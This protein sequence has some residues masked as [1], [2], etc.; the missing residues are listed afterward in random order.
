MWLT[1]GLFHE[2]V[3]ADV[4]VL[5]GVRVVMAGGDAL[6]SRHCRRV[7]DEV[8]GVRLVNV[9][10]PTEV[11]I[12]ATSHVVEGPVFLGGAALDT[13]VWVLDERLCPVGVGVEGELYV[14]GIGLAHGYGGRAGMTA[15]RFVALPGGSGERMYRTGDL[16]RWTA[17][18]VLDFVGRVDDQVKVRGFRVELGEVEEVLAGFPGVSR[19]VVVVRGDAGGVKRL[20]AYAVVEAGAGAES[21]A[22]VGVDG[23]VLRGFLARVLPDYMVPSVCVVVDG[24]PL[25]ANGKVDRRALPEPDPVLLCGGE[26]VAPRGVREGVVVGVFAEVLGLERVGVRDDFFGLGGDSIR[27][28]QVVSRLRRAGVVVPVRVL[29]DCRT[30]EGV[31]AAADDQVGDQVSGGVGLVPVGRGGV[32]PLSFAQARVWFAAEIDPEGTEYN[33]GGA[34]RIRGPLDVTALES[35]LGALVVRH[36]SLRTT[37][38]TVDGQGVQVIHP[39]NPVTLPVREATDEEAAAAVRAELETPFDLST[40]PLLRPLLLRTAEDEHLLVLSMHHIVT[41]GWSV[42]VLTRELAALYAG[43]PLPELPVQYADYAVWQRRTLT[44]PVL[45]EGL[46]YWREQLAGA[47]VLDLPTDRPRPAVR[48]RAGSTY[49][50]ELPADLVDRFAEV[51]R[52]RGVTLFMGLTAAVQLMLA[53]TTGQRD[54]VLGTATIGRDRPELEDV[55]GFFVNTLALRTRIDEAA[56][57]T[58]LLA[59]VRETVLDAFAHA[60]MPFDRVVDAVVSERDPART[61]LVQAMMVLQTSPWKSDGVRGPSFAAADLPRQDAQF[62]LTFEFWEHADGMRF[63]LNHNT[64]LFDATTVHS[65]AEHLTEVLGVLA[66]TPEL[67]LSRIPRLP[68]SE[69]T[70]VLDDWAQGPDGPDGAVLTDVFAEQVARAPEAVALVCG[71]ERTTYGELDARTSRLAH[72]LRTHGVGP[73][74]RVGV[75]LPRGTEPIVALLAVLKAGGVFVP[76]DTSY[77]AERLSYMVQDSGVEL[78]LADAS[79]AATVPGVGTPVLLLAE[80]EDLAAVCSK[81][82]Q[83]PPQVALAPQN[84]AYVFYTSGSTGRPK[85]IVLPHAGVLRVAR[86]PRL[87]TTAA[88]VVGQFATLSFDAS[89]LEIWSAFANGAA[90]V[91]STA[92]V[93]SV[94]ELGTLL[95]GRGVTVAWLT[96]GLFHEVVDTDVTML[97]GLRLLMAGGDALAPQHCRTV[98]ERLPQVRLVNGYGP[99]ETTVF[100]AVHPVEAGSVGASV[101]IGSPLGRTGAYVL[102]NWLRPVPAGAAGELYIAGEGVARGY[103]GHPGLTAGRFLP[104][105]FGGPG[106][107]MYRTGDVVRW[108]PDGQLEFV[109]RADHQV[110]VRGFRIEIGEIESALAAHPDVTQA[111][112]TVREGR[113]GAKRLVGYVVGDRVDHAGMREFVAKSLPDYMIPTAFVVVGTFPLT[114]NGKVDRRALPE[115]DL[116]TA[117]AKD[118]VA[119][120][121]RTERIVARAWGDVLGVERVGVQDNFFELG[122]DSILSIQ[123]VSRLRRAGLVVSPQDVLVRQ[124]VAGVAAV[125][126]E[127]GAVDAGPAVTGPV[128]LSPIQEWFLETRTVAPDHFGMSMHVRLAG[129]VDREVLAR[130]VPV[131]LSHHEG[132]WV[133][134][135]RTA[136]GWRQRVGGPVRVVVERGVGGVV[137]EGFRLE[138]GPLVRVVLSGDRLLIAVHHMVVDGVSWRILLEDIAVAYRQLA[139]GEDVVLDG[140]SLS[141]PE[142]TARLAAHDF[143]GQAEYWTEVLASTEPLFDDVPAGTNTVADTA[144]ETMTLSR[145]ETEALLQRVPSV[146]RTQVNDVLLAA[147]GRALGEWSGRDRILVDVEGHGREEAVIGADVSR[148]VGWFTSIYPVALGSSGDWREQIRSTKEMLRAVPDRGIGFGALR[149]LHGADLADPAQISFNYLGRYDAM[150]DP[151]VFAGMLPVDGDHAPADERPH[152]WDVVSRVQDGQLRIDLHHPAAA[153]DAARAREFAAR[154]RDALREAVA[155][156]LTDGT[157]GRTPSDFPLVAWDQATVDRVVGTG[158]GIADVHPLSPMQQGLLFHSL[159][160]DSGTAYVEQ[161]SFVLEGADDPQRLAAAWQEAVNASDAL[162]VSV[163][164]DQADEPAALV[165]ERVEIPVHTEDWTALDAAARAERLADLRRGDFHTIRLGHAPLMRLSLATLGGTRVQLVWTFHHLLLDGWSTP[166]LLDDVFTRY[167][168]GTP[169]VRAPYRDYLAW[170]DARDTD[171]DR[172]HWRT[173][174]AGYDTALTLPADPDAGP[175]DG[176]RHLDVAL[177]GTLPTEIGEFARRHRLTV[178]A[179]IQGA[180]A[181]LLSACSG[182]NDIVFGATTSGRPA[183]LA[184]AEGMLGLFIN[185]V[186]VRTVLDPAT[187]VVQ[188]LQQLQAEQWES[189]AHEYLSLPELT[190][191]ADLPAGTRLFES[192]LVF[193]NYPV[194][195]DLAARHGLAVTEADAAVQGGDYPLSLTAFTGRQLVGDNAPGVSLRVSYDPAVFGDR[196][197]RR[198][199]ERLATLLRGLLD[200]ESLARIPLLTPAER[201]RFTAGT[202][203]ASGPAGRP[204]PTVTLPGLFEAQAAR[205]PEAPAVVDGGTVLSY[206]ELDARA[207]GLAHRL[208]GSGI[209][210]ETVVGVSL[211]RGVD[212]LVSLLAV[213]KTGAVYLPLDPAHPADRLAFMA[214]DAGAR[215]VLG[216]SAAPE[217]NAVDLLAL[218]PETSPVPPVRPGHP[219]AAAYL[220]YTS[221]S[222]G[223]PKGVAVTHRGLRDLGAAHARALDLDGDSRILQSVSLGFDV[224]MGDLVNAWTVG[225]ALVLAG[226]D[227]TVGE[228]LARLLEEQRITHAML[229]LA[230]L[231]TLPDIP[232][233]HLRAL[234]SGGEAMPAEIPARWAPGRILVNAYG[235]TETTVAATLSDPLAPATATPPIG[236]AID[237]ARA[238]VLDG[239]LRPV[240]DGT[241]GELHLAGPGVARGYAGRPGL[242]ASAFVANPFTGGRMYRTGDLVRRR[243]DGQLEF[244][245]RTDHQVKVRGHRIEPGEVEAALTRHPAVSQAVAVVREDQPGT[246]RLVGYAVADGAHPAELREFVAR[247]LPE[248]MV[249]AVCVVLDA[250]PLNA[251]GKVDRKALPAPDLSTLVREYIAPATEAERA[252]ATVFAEVLGAERIGAADDFFGLGGDSLLSIQAVSRLR[253]A[254]YPAAVRTL[255]DH[256]TVAALAAEIGAADDLPGAFGPDAPPAPAARD[257]GALP[258][259]YAQRRLWF[260]AELDPESTEYNSGGALRL[261]GPLDLAAL[262]GALDALV[263]RHEPLRTT[264]A[265]ADGEAVQLIGPAAP[266][267]LP[268]VRCAPADVPGRIRAGLGVVFD[269][270]TGPLLRPTL[271]KVADE[272]HILVLAMHHM[273]TDGWS[274]GVVVRELDL[275]YRGVELPPLALQYADYAAW[276]RE[277]LTPEALAAGLDHWRARLA[278]APVLELPTDRPR[279]AERTWAG[280]LAEFEVPAEVVAR[281]TEVCRAR[282]VTL[283]MGLVAAVQLVLARYSGQQDVVVGT[284]TSGRDRAEL[285]DLIGFFVNTVALRT[286]IDEQRSVADLLAAVR[287]TVLDA[288]A[289]EEIPFDRVVDAVV[290]ER[291]PSRTPLVQALVSMETTPRPTTGAGLTWQDQ[292]FDVD[293]AQFELAVDFAERDGSLTAVINYNTGLF[294][295]ATVRGLGAHLATVVGEIAGPDKPLADVRMLTPEEEHT[296]THGWNDTAQ[297]IPE[298]LL[299]ELFAAQAARTPDAV[300]LVHGEERLTFAELDRAAG[301]LAHRLRERG[302]GPDTVVGICA[303][304]GTDVVVAL[305]GILRAGA[306]CLPIDPGYPADRVRHMLAD[307]GAATVLVQDHLADRFADYEGILLTPDRGSEGDPQAPAVPRLTADHL[308]YV[309]YTSGS[310]G[311]PKGTLIRHGAFR[312]LFAHHRRRMFEPTSRGR[313]MRM[314]QTASISFDASCVALLWLVGGH[315]LHPVDHETHID[316]R[317]FRDYLRDARIDVIDEAPTYL[318]ELIADGLLADETHVPSVIVFGGEAVDGQI[319]DTLRAHPEVTAYNFYGPTECTCDSLTW[320]ARGS[321]RPLIGRPVGNARA[322]VL[323]AR[324]RPVPAG[325]VG[326]LYIEG[327]GL[328]RGYVGKPGLTAGR[329]VACPFTGGRMYRSGDLVRWTREGTVEFL[330]R[331]DDQVKVRGF[332]IELGEIETVLARHPAVTQAVVVARE[333]QPGVKRLVAYVVGT[334]GADGADAAELR[335]YAADA[336]PDYMVP[337]AWLLLDAFP[338]NQSGK[339]DR[340]AL[341]APDPAA[342]ANAYTAPRTA[343]EK[344]VAAVWADVLGLERIGAHDNFFD[345]GGDSILSTRAVSRLRAAGYDTSVRDLFNAPTVAGLAPLATPTREPA[346][347]VRPVARDGALPLSYAQRRLWF[348]AELDPESTEYN[349]GIALRL[350][351][352]LDLVALRGALDALVAR[353]ESL[354]TTFTTAE[355]Q[356]VQIVHPAAPVPLPVVEPG[357]EG[358]DALVRSLF[359]EVFDLRGGPLLRPTLVRIGDRDHILVLSMHHI[360][361]DGWSM[362]VITRE[363]TGLYEGRT[364]AEPPVQYADYAVWQRERLTPQAMEHALDYWREQLAGAPVLELP[365]DRPRPA[366]RTTRGASFRT[367]IPAGLLARFTE[368][369]QARGATLFMGLTAA[370]KLLLS[371]Y[372]GQQDVV[373]GT[374][375][376]G[377]DRAELEGLVGF[378]VNTLAL[379]TTIDENATGTALLSSVRRTV[380]DAFA[381][382]EVPFDRVVDAVVTERDPSRSPLVQAVISYESPAEGHGAA[383]A[384]PAALSWSDHPLESRTS[385][386]DLTFDFGESDGEFQAHLVHNTDLFDEATI[387]RMAGHLVTI[388]TAL[389]DDPA[390]PLSDLELLSENE[391]LTLLHE[392]NATGSDI[393]PLSL[394]ALFERQRSLRPAA[395]AVVT[396]TGTWTYAQIDDRATALARRLRAEGVTPETVVG[397]CLPRGADWI[398]ALLAVVKAGGVY[399]PLDPEYPADRRAFMLTDSGAP[400]VLTDGDR[401]G[402]LDATAARTLLVDDGEGHEAVLQGRDGPGPVSPDAGAYLIYTSGSTGVPKG[403]LVGHRG[404]AAFAAT[405]ADRFTITPE[406]RVLQV[407]SANFDASVMEILMAWSV[408]A[409]LVLPAPGRVLGEELVEVLTRQRVTHAMVPPAALAGAGTAELPELRT[410]VVG[411]EACPPELV[412][413]WAPGRAMYNAY[414]PTEITISATIS[415]RLAPGTVPPIGRP[416][417]DT[418]VYVLDTWLRPVPAGVPGELYVTGAGVARGYLGRP[419][420]TAS[421]FVASPFSAERMY[422]TGDVVRWLPGGQLEFVGRADD[423]VKIRGFRIEPG[424]IESV[425]AA[426]PDVRQAVV[427]VREDQPGV[428]RLVAYVTGDAPGAAPD[429]ETLREHTA[430]SLPEYMVPAAWVALDTIPLTANGKLDRRA[431]PAPGLPARGDTYTAPRTDAERTLAGVWQALLGVPEVGVHDNF[432]DLGGDSILSIQVVARARDAGLAVSTKQLFAA[433]TVAALAELAVQAGP[434]SGAEGPG[435]TGPV[436]GDV[437]LTPIQR[438]FLDGERGSYDRFTMSAYA[439]LAERPDRDA[440]R[441]A[442]GALYEHHD[443]LRSRFTRTGGGWQ[444]SVVEREDGNWFTW[445]DLFQEEP[446]ARA[447]EMERQLAR[448]HAGLDITHGPLLKALVFDQGVDLPVRIALVA[449]HLVV[450]VVSWGVLLA[451]LARAYERIAAGERPG[452]GARTTSFQEWSGRLA[453]LA[454]AGRFDGEIAYWQEAERVPRLPGSGSAANTA[455]SEDTVSVRLDGRTTAALLQSAPGA[456]RARVNE[457]LL[458][459]LGRALADWTG[460]DRVAVALEGHG[461]EEAVVEGADLSRT[462]GWFTTVFPFAWN[463]SGGEGW[464]SAVAGVKRGLRAVP[465]KGLGYGVLRHLRADSP[466]GRPLPDVSFNYVGRSDGFDPGFYAGL[467]EDPSAT[468][469]GAGARAH[470]LDVVCGVQDERLTIG[471]SYSTAVH[472]RSDIDRL[473]ARLGD[474]LHDLADSSTAPQA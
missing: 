285:E 411:G 286:R 33:T 121:T 341:P 73:E 292:P 248:Y 471:I 122:G 212:W 74:T 299:P 469:S 402:L 196:A 80:L 167:A 242:T 198:L 102:D 63:S 342:L 318:R 194:A 348:A 156:C 31:A 382:S 32:V 203:T 426:H 380:L 199:S 23:S 427:Q 176:I 237:G 17:E 231:S 200:E 359:A 6:S 191:L 338:L 188:W 343:A 26:Y 234:V 412:D 446:A 435:D 273:I 70:L 283:F 419:A 137:Q 439:E 173:V 192:V 345:L 133:R 404:V 145:A 1:A 91:V 110:K 289:H 390:R 15:G 94:E 410:L 168:G 270:R 202:G 38:A 370:A 372:S 96:A 324:L 465:H 216:N 366:E 208:A 243:T 160:D 92:R 369:C 159:E 66:R 467:L 85:G 353:H 170:L 463:V 351:G 152:V 88:D 361:T 62:E 220:I 14:S 64:D 189:R 132:L 335:G 228:P 349:S 379:R 290:T 172:T 57:G 451:D 385:Q 217:L 77:P 112:V 218:G 461:R 71:D 211:P 41:D 466:L 443:G 89:A 180:W 28:V 105:P 346:D 433:P 301:R 235:P 413:R 316:L 86:D 43:E 350:T 274:M 4:R 457:V 257:G 389:A 278:G 311:L 107:R 130:A 184:E 118:H 375:T 99:T 52:T 280:A 209:G 215:L 178:N 429:P 327:A 287:E 394:P 334:G 462:V 431:L 264:F 98:L 309:I 22:G 2:V 282:G 116:G 197:A 50:T 360:V 297:D 79:T 18:G 386:F 238:F 357:A 187:P 407:A 166:Q 403:V 101:P 36:E 417:L 371:R 222:T 60:E 354:R 364:P 68:A 190:A 127:A 396:D 223:T 162:R 253:R 265:E 155:Y 437:A 418:K 123:V 161:M 281:F 308:A 95:H 13:G 84:A 432:F 109:G 470:L 195:D 78:L 272:E 56:T 344:T 181:L 398:T 453:E 154:Y 428:K 140:T 303:D 72:A 391:R 206:G 35:A 11:S 262:R 362:N 260:A 171:A 169:Q 148:T 387:R 347:P 367:V 254:G 436:T 261:T 9:Y 252:V 42:N 48:T 81:G 400:V 464:R 100:A 246:R 322:F 365:T 452:P 302:A 186:P 448:A 143:S 182:R 468:Q 125:A 111:V 381:H 250:F 268:V 87:G 263:A 251:N 326:E 210:P 16:V 126:R 455:G 135:S 440:L 232:L 40:G 3:D 401:A 207:N 441:A 336:L 219:D 142:W 136:E 321:E 131:V 449:H 438:W 226:P 352:A 430:R 114:A 304:R 259:S 46:A 288:F 19:A 93:L 298:P 312:N 53:R 249:P 421:R 39:A 236:R 306:A 388:L 258:L 47:P 83:S 330:G 224:A 158:R 377:R 201:D 12:M 225:A 179:V 30:A 307:S 69:R 384:A 108:L 269:L 164:W 332:R 314:A 295:E 153:H 120:R 294:D 456:Y 333:D 165:H 376:S 27:A 174:L 405:Q 317:A 395:P 245:G 458:A 134:F 115:P 65:M 267:D 141:F 328:A 310:T 8:P 356:G 271:L 34:V 149:H 230:A 5:G 313:Q 293:T 117:L 103:V 323:D 423:Q 320:T 146:F 37:F 239:W 415:E 241:A 59:S 340:R 325:V 291:D 233:P 473:A 82:I 339:V 444:Q 305:L 472:D 106:E 422:R 373:L 275:L 51:C 445:Y 58:E 420:L 7:L 358:A 97:S 20:V 378:F 331:R 393:A 474:L 144:I 104:S 454:P 315:Q 460:Q 138:G 221:G 214:A 337:A 49:D 406:S 55:L 204:R 10:G 409:A 447:A 128:V 240:P 284:V 185:T 119:P 163:V 175:A 139:A 76:L 21:G 374:V 255:F 150:G 355:G 383:A 24:L 244:L 90:L 44:G 147:L 229:P 54:V 183:D 75:C 266:V 276:Q 67:P 151:D 256:P 25:T 408:G 113:N 319:W 434:G 124:T 416:N 425:L 392:R 129:G 45:D 277:R 29:F 459:A 247:S 368:F 442:V 157:G 397:V 424:E 399:L 227:Q 279:P 296:L 450:D 300:A 193:E 205:R 329:F 213:A 363:L 414:G 61:P 177:P